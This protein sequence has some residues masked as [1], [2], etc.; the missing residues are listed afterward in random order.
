MAIHDFKEILLKIGFIE[1]MRTT[2][3]NE[4]VLKLLF[5]WVPN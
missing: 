4:E 1:Q 3:G 2:W 5:E